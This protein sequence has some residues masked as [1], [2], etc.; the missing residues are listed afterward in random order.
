VAKIDDWAHEFE[1]CS[2]NQWKNPNPKQDLPLSI[3]IRKVSCEWQG[4]KGSG[5]AVCFPP[6]MPQWNL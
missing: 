6:Y 3:L 1:F 4:L 5:V 2:V